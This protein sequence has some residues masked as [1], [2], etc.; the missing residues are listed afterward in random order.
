MREGLHVFLPVPGDGSTVDEP[1]Y[2]PESLTN[3]EAY[4]EYRL[5]SD[6][7]KHE[8]SFGCEPVRCETMDLY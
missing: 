4:G 3:R 8:Y 1:D 7:K 2:M 5:Q 6:V